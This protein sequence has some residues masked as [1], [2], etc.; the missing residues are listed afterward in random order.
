M[1]SASRPRNEPKQRQ[2]EKN[3]AAKPRRMDL[4]V[5]P[6]VKAWVAQ[7]AAALTCP[8]SQVVEFALRYL[9]QAM[10]EG[11]ID[12][13]AYTSPLPNPRYHQSLEFPRD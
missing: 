5:D 10:D 12:L 7:Q 2:A 6:E 11:V 3:E 13:N 4:L 8:Q 9:E 1:S